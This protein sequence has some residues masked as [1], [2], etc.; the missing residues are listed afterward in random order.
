MHAAKTGKFM[1]A[2]TLE[3]SRLCVRCHEDRNPVLATPHDLRKS[4]PLE[5]NRLE[6][7]PEQSG[8]CGACH[9]F[10]RYAREPKP[11]N[12]DPTGRCATCHPASGTGT[13]RG[14]AMAH[15]AEV[16]A[17]KIPS[18]SN[19]KLSPHAGDQ[20]KQSL[21]C[22]TCHDP[23]T[24]GGGVAGRFLRAPNDQLCATCHTERA[25]SLAGKHDFT[26]RPELKNARGR[27]AAESGKCGFCHAVHPEGNSGM[28]A[29]TRD[30]PADANGLCTQCHRD[31]GLAVRTKN[32][33]T[34][35]PTGPNVR[36]TT[37]TTVAAL[38]LF[39]E[40][41]AVAADGF[42]AC[43]SCHDAHANSAKR[44]GLMRVPGPTSALCTTC[45]VDNAAMASGAHDA[46][47]KKTF[48]VAGPAEDLC[49]SC[50]RPHGDDATK[51]GFAFVPTAGLPRSDAACVA[52]HPK[53][54]VGPSESPAPGTLLHPTTVPTKHAA[55]SAGLPLPKTTGA[56]SSIG[57][58]TCHN[59]H[60]R[61]DAP[62]L[63]R[64]EAGATPAAMCVRC[65]NEAEPLPRSM[66]AADA[67][68]VSGGGPTCG[69]CHATH[70]V[71]GSQKHLLWARGAVAESADPDLRCLTC[72]TT[73]STGR[74]ILVQHPADAIK[75]MPWSTTQPSTRPVAAEIHCVTCHTTHGDP[76]AHAIPDLPTRR[77]ARPMVRPD[78]ARQ[79]AY[80]HGAAA[81]RV[82]LYWHQTD[83]RNKENPLRGN[84][85]PDSQ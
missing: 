47:G 54:A 25:A 63:A 22:S 19:L 78:P 44:K 2:D 83:K 18:T 5:K 64:V 62:K 42:V 31:G 15:P 34:S 74:E 16:A 68:K 48:G 79:C 50:H 76:A 65:H 30:P 56:G 23:H 4:K 3:A 61:A 21:T 60:A 33:V 58:K 77:A 6:Q 71:E 69:P 10:H 14:L 59:P 52:C 81:P 45:H 73:S 27:S 28:W 82:L 40:Q 72:H 17:G 13:Q 26:T 57:C 49:T 85:L 36:P 39:N 12:A 38:P 29:A 84:P 20:S 75:L 9:S 7:T 11:G 67:L 37:R 41:G 24:A 55:Q 43:A 51:Q 32:A 35:H 53:Q 66:H 1:L 8:P 70:A 46:R 80:C